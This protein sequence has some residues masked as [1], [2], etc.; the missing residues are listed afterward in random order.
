MRQK[1]VSDWYEFN[2]AIVLLEWFIT[3]VFYY[4]TCSILGIMI[5]LGQQGFDGITDQSALCNKYGSLVISNVSV[6][7][8]PMV[9]F[10]LNGTTIPELCNKMTQEIQVSFHTCT[11]AQPLHLYLHFVL[12]SRSTLD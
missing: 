10:M 6:I 4:L 5:I 12:I 3:C 9:S 11:S 2:Q 7:N 8:G 1:P